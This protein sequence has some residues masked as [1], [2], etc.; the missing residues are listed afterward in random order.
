MGHTDLSVFTP[1]FF[2]SEITLE[3]VYVTIWGSGDINQISCFQDKQCAFCII[4]LVPRIQ[5][6]KILRI[7]TCS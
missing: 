4:S 2:L 5:V 3:G 1:I 7:A 6:L